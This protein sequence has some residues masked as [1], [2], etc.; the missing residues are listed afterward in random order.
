VRFV[1]V[2]GDSYRA[3]GLAVNRPVDRGVIRITNGL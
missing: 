3:D 2:V 1:Q